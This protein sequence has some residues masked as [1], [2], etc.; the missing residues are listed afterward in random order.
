MASP[1]PQPTAITLLKGNPG[2][3]PINQNEPEFEL[4]KANENPPPNWLTE[5]QKIFWADISV[6][7]ENARVLTEADLPL[8]S[9]LCIA[10]SELKFAN[11]QITKVGR[12][13]KTPSGYVQQNPYVGMMH[14]AIKQ[15]R[16]I[17]NEFGMTPAARTRINVLA[18]VSPDDKWQTFLERNGRKKA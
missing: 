12:L 10:L 11:D 5:D 8:L 9:C 6:L 3:R 18:G 7:L 14:T 4:V 17:A 1:I 15:I 13:M 2:K 16:S